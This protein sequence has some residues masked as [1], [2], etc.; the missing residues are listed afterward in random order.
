M[1]HQMK[2]CPEPF[3]LIRTGNKTIELRLNDEKRQ[4]IRIG[5]IVEFT[6]T[7][8][9]EKLTAEVTDLFQFDS[10]AELYQKI[11]SCIILLNSKRNMVFLVLK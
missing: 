1:K 3:E 4:K 10:F 7:E 6:Q 11:W 9:G 2:L 8:T 5:D